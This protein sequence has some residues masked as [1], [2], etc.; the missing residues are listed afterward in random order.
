MNPYYESPKPCAICGRLPEFEYENKLNVL[1]CG[2]KDC[3]YS[4]GVPGGSDKKIMLAI[5]KWNHCMI[6]AGRSRFYFCDLADYTPG[7]KCEGVQKSEYDDE[8]PDECK[9]CKDYYLYDEGEV[10]TNE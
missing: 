8:P 6:T 9:E 7:G 5:N 4:D 1:K 2:T 3:K 10:T